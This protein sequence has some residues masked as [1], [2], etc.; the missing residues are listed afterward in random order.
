MPLFLQGSKILD[1]V[2]NPAI[3]DN[4]VRGLNKPVRINL[5]IGCQ[6]DNKADVRPFRSLNRTDT[7][8]MGRVNIPHFKAGTFTG[9]S[10][11]SQCG[12]STL[13][14]HLGQRVGLIHEL[15]QLRSTKKFLDSSGH[16]LGIYQVMGH[17]GLDFLQAHTLLDGTL[18]P[19]QSHAVLIFT[20]LTHR[21]YPPVTEMINIITVTQIIFQPYQVLDT[22]KNIIF[23][24]SPMLN[25]GIH[26]KLGVNLVAAD[27]GKII[28]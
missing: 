20:E 5:G 2:G 16:R 10:S 22:K 9:Q 27:H 11:G 14:S 3:V 28:G 8:V 6:R 24:Q 7:S 4:T 17:Q 18:H 25:R 1:L 12:Q 13:M 21:A 23:C 26:S 19:D 15:G